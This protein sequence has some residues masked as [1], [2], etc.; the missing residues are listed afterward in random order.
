MPALRLG[1]RL[2]KGLREDVARALV[3]DRRRHGAFVD[4]NDV[5][6]RARLD[7]RARLA[8]ARAGAFDM[9]A[10]HRR[11]AMWVAMDPRPPLFARLPDEQPSLLPPSE[12]EVLLLDYATV[13]LSVDDHPMRH[14]RPTLVER[15]SRRQRGRRPL[16]D[17][18]DVQQCRQGMRVLVAGLVI[19]RQRPGT[20]DGTCFITLE[21]EYGHVNVVV[22]GRDY[23]RWRTTIITSRV[24]LVDA[25]IEREGIVIHAM[26]RGVVAVSTT[27]QTFVGER[28]DTSSTQMALPF[29]SRDFH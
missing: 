14:V 26:A 10:G 21:D 3:D 2:I 18:R 5:N 27:S 25:V 19:G 8:L 17:S 13:G 12:G 9:L 11:A 16:L 15:L 20:A 29:A 22:W 28:A 24:L 1:L 6:R 4:I 23:E 7:K